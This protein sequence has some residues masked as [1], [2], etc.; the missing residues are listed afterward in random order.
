[1][2]ALGTSLLGLTR[3]PV[4]EGT[5]AQRARRFPTPPLQQLSSG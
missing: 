5:N 3:Q 1:M 4:R 2:T